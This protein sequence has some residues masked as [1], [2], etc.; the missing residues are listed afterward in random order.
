[1]SFPFSFEICEGGQPGQRGSQIFTG[2]GVPSNSLGI[3]RDL[4]IDTT[5]GNYYSKIGG[6]WVLVG[7]IVSGAHI[8]TGSGAPSNSLGVDGDIYIDTLSNNYYQKIS[9]SWVLQGSFGFSDSESLF[10]TWDILHPSYFKSFTYSAGNLTDIDLWTDNTETIH[11]FNKHFN[12]TLGVLTSIVITKISNS[13]T[14][15]RTFGYSG[16][17]LISINVVQA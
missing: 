2:S 16:G 4:Y 12:Y 3:D 14:E 11:L 8:L 1:M 6:V 15:T 9:G 7:H 10:L 5:S 17:V 13:M